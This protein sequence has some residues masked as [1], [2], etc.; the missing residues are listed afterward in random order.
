MPTVVALDERERPY[1]SS[2]GTL[3]KVRV[4]ANMIRQEP[5][6]AKSSF[7]GSPK[8]SGER[9]RHAFVSHLCT[10]WLGDFSRGQNGA[11][12]KRSRPSQ[13]TPRCVP[14]SRRKTPCWQW[15]LE[16]HLGGSARAHNRVFVTI[17]EQAA[18]RQTPATRASEGTLRLER[19]ISVMPC[20]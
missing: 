5:A 20:E 4:K 13:R 14:R 8:A 2:V 17:Q 3:S 6:P 7:Q 18:T 12:Q 11:T 15:R 19:E 1:C 9:R 10:V 16:S